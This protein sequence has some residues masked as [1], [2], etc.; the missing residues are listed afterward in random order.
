MQFEGEIERS[1]EKN[2][3]R[4]KYEKP[5]FKLEEKMTFMYEGI[6]AIAKENGIEYVCRQCSSCHGCR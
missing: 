1:V 5:F 4:R 3:K 2:F 6:K